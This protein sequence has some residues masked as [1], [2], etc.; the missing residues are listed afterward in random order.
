MTRT[1]RPAK[2]AKDRQSEVIAVR[3]TSAEYK[4][5]KRVS[6]ATKLNESDV[7]RRCIKAGLESVEIW[8][9]Q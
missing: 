5:L 4:E 9:K 2:P 8:R 6:K 1:G 3:L 7:L